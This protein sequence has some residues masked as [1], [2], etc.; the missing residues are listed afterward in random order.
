MKKFIILLLIFT[1]CLSAQ[2]ASD[3][4]PAE[5]GYKWFYKITPFD[6]LNVPIDS[7]VSYQ[8]DSFTTVTDYQNKLSN[9]VVSKYGT[10]DNILQ[11]PWLDTSYIHLES[12]NIWNYVDDLEGLGGLSFDYEGW[13]STYRLNV[14]TSETYTLFT[15]DTLITIDLLTYTVTI[16]V[17]GR[18]VN[19]QVI[20]TPF[21][22]LNCKKFIITA[23]VKAKLSI[24]PAVTLLSMPDTIYISPGHYIVKSVRP[25]AVMDLSLFGYP[26]VTFPGGMTEAISPPA[27]L[28]M[29]PLQ[30]IAKAD[31]DTLNII[32]NNAGDNNLFWNASVLNGDAWINISSAA[33]GTDGDTL[34]LIVYPN[35]T[36]IQRLGLIEISAP[37]AFNAP[38]YIT[39]TQMEK[40]LDVKDSDKHFS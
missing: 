5:T 2:N 34:V 32:I 15:K 37:E 1:G 9:V 6:S 35:D 31:G 39:V 25:T 7:M 16:T 4:F 3:Y 18:R 30:Y 36:T 27:V 17:T 23:A 21:G 11:M 26:S 20:T 40:I 14:S 29:N 24:F 10:S 33:A 22:D 12:S 8:I 13:Y 38:R 19:D 28:S